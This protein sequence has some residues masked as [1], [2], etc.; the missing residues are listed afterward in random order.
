LKEPDILHQSGD[1]WVIENKATRSY[2]VVELRG[3]CGH[4]LDRIGLGYRQDGYATALD[5]AKHVCDR[6][7]EARQARNP[8]RAV[9]A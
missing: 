4:V 6:R 8:K 3:A 2:E 5:W 1:C 7:E 9:E